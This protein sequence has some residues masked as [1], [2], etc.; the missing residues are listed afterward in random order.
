LNEENHKLSNYERLKNWAESFLQYL[1]KTAEVGQDREVI[2]TFGKGKRERKYVLLKENLIDIVRYCKSRT[3]NDFIKPVS[4][5]VMANLLMHFASFI[6][7]PF[8][9]VKREDIESFF[10]HYLSSKSQ[11]YNLMFRRIIKPFFRWVYGYEKE[12]GYPDVVRWIR[13]SVR[14]NG[15]NKELEE[16]EILSLEEI[17]KMIEVCD[18]LRDRALIS[19]LYESGTRASE[20]LCLKIKDVHF[21]EY[22]AY[23]LVSG[24]TGSR[25][26]RLV[27]SVVD[28]KNWLNVHPRK[29]DPNAYLFCSITKN[30]K[31]KGQPLSES[32]LL[33]I[34]KQ[35]ANKAKISKKIYPHLFRHSRATHLA[36]H[37]TEQE[38]KK[39]F[40]WT[41]NSGMAS[42]YVHLSG[43]DLDNKLLAINGVKKEGEEKPPAIPTVKC[44]KC[45]EINSIGNKFCSKCGAPLDLKVVEKLEIVKQVVSQV[46][47]FIFSKMKER[48]IGEQDLDNVIQ[49]WY[50]KNSQKSS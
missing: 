34:L 20:L 14:K 4:V 19:V 44:Y 27:S 37:L 8:K 45:A 26:I 12:D 47:M 33:L 42:V 36:K 25:R 46:T 9:E 21:D 7:K 32:G 10:E 29:N 22:G 30:N 35:T 18:N 2:L 23:L 6:K 41:P 31:S 3:E 16:L 13:T 43:A 39:Y 15:N 5:H 24:K 17:A 1:E 49:E 40:G 28:L 48:K 50:E 38:L 11:N